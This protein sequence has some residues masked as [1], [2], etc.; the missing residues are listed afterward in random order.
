M[1]HKDPVLVLAGFW[2]FLA[3]LRWTL[4][5]GACSEASNIQSAQGFHIFANP[6]AQGTRQAAKQKAE[7]QNARTPI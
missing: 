7:S 5:R 6:Y 2:L 3:L 1:L 4:L